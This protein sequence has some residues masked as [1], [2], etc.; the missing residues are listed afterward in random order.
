MDPDVAFDEPFSLS[1]L[2][3]VAVIFGDILFILAS[4]IFTSVMP[5]IAAIVSTSSA[6]AAGVFVAFSSAASAETTLIHYH[7]SYIIQF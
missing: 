1:T 5:L 3:N 6:A 2:S 7:L 4:V